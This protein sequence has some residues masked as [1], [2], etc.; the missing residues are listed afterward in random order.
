MDSFVVVP[1]KIF[2]QSFPWFGHIQ[3]KFLINYPVSPFHRSVPCRRRF[4]NEI[5]SDASLPQILMKNSAVLAPVVAL[6]SQYGKRK[7][8]FRF[9]KGIDRVHGFQA[10]RHHGVLSPCVDINESSLVLP[11]IVLPNIF[12]VHLHDLAGFPWNYG[13]FQR[14]VPGQFLLRPPH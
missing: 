11:L 10:F 8:F 13:V 7:H 9:F 3:I 5:M 14:F 6:H 12:G 4:G 1:M 2:G